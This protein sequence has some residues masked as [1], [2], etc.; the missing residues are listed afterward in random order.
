MAA[1]GGA[2]SKAGKLEARSPAG[3]DE[4]DEFDDD[5]PVSFPS[6][7]NVTIEKVSYEISKNF[8]EFSHSD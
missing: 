4:E 3:N 7:V 8:H 1:G 6:R 5:Q 2:Q